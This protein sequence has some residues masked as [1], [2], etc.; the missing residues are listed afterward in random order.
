MHAFAALG[1]LALA[2]ML[3][4]RRS[5]EAFAMLFPLIGAL[6]FGL[7]YTTEASTRL[8]AVPSIAILSSAFVLHVAGALR[9]RRLKSASSAILAFVC[10]AFLVNVLAPWASGAKQPAARDHRLL[11]VVYETQGKGTLALDQY[12]KATRMAPRNSSC[13]LSLGAMLASDGVAD[14][15]E[16]HFLAAAALDTLSPAPYLGLANLYRRNGFL[17]QALSSLEKAVIRAPYDVGLAVSLGRSCIDMGLYE[18]AE[19]HFRAALSVDPENGAA[20]DGLLE[21]RDRGVYVEVQERPDRPRETTR[22]RTQA[23][24]QHLRRGNL[25]ASKT[26]LD[27]LL[28]GD[29]DDLD[30]VFAMATWHLTAGNLEQAIEGYERCHESNTKNPL[31]MNNLASAY[32]Q[33][34]R[35]EEA[36]AMW[37]RLLA[38]DP[39][40][41]KAKTNLQ[42]ALS[43]MNEAPSE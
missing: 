30:I 19:A 38:L 36:I 10:A 14:E 11:G 31:V 35:V 22:A 4:T 39:N 43:E 32:H 1:A 12:D 26:I 2:G 3:T 17:E 41:I 34:G 37:R 13:R 6:T 20:I 9:D 24:M 33:T 5:P 16:R 25:E 40:N 18:R 8:L 42:R 7:V 23:A 28:A 27:E 29:P 21:L 15:A